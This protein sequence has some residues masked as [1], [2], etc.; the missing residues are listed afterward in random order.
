MDKKRSRKLIAGSFRDPSGHLFYQDGIL[1]RQINR[2]YRQN[3]ETLMHSGLY[4]DL[5]NNE[6]IIRHAEMSHPDFEANDSFKVI[7]PQPLQ[8][9][10]YPYEWCFSQLKHAALAT[11]AIQKRALDH[12]MVLKDASAYN[13]QFFKGHP[14]LIDTLSF[15]RYE[16]GKP[17][18]AYKQFCQ[19]FLAPLALMS[20]KDVRLSQL[21]RIYI[22]GVP[23]DLASAILPLSTYLRM[24]LFLHVHLHAKSQ[25][26]FSDKAIKRNTR[27]FGVKKLSLLGLITN[28]QTTIHNLKWRHKGTEWGEYYKKTNYSH[29][30][31]EHKK[32]L[33]HSY[34][35]EIDAKTVWDLGANTGIFSRMGNKN[36]GITVSFDRDPAA[37]ERNYIESIRRK[38]ENILPLVLDLTNPS[39]GIGWQNEERTSLMD[40][41]PADVVLA[42]ALIH[43]LAIS[44][45]VPFI[46]IAAFLSKI[47]GFLIMEFVPKSDSQVQKLLATREDV[48]PLYTQEDFEQSSGQYFSIIHSKRIKNTQ[49]TLYLMRKI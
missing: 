5:V 43:H 41:G 38:E 26:H 45:H 36:D 22:D 11:L 4:D 24:G 40:R 3:Y 29:D 33:V 17:W 8:F 9:V 6:L 42:L 21:F 20:H 35:T 2:M 44:N 10:S 39:S 30:G 7:R 28:L 34:L 15:E 48:F 16:E 14:V 13:I 37:V 25:K 23:L 47:C 12:E 18:I 46:R 32:E 27:K 31:F 1:Y 49:R 19:H